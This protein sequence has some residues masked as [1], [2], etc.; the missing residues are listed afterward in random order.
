M[1]YKFIIANIIIW[2][3]VIAPAFSIAQ[4]SA[5]TTPL[6]TRNGNIVTKP[7]GWLI[8]DV[9]K[10]KVEFRNK[11]MQDGQKTYQTSYDTKFIEIPRMY[12]DGTVDS[13]RK[14][15]VYTL[16]SYDIDK[17]VFCYRMRVSELPLEGEQGVGVLWDKIYYDLDGDGKFESWDTAAVIRSPL[18]IPQWAIKPVAKGDK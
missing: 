8:P 17:R 16:I 15:M 18:I 3:C 13:Q 5:Q 2:I 7:D 11:F 14:D 10:F 6:V 9:S 12:K 1:N 4:T